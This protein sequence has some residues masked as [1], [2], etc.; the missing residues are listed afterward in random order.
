MSFKVSSPQEYFDTL[1]QRFIAEGA[2]GVTATYQF[3]LDPAG[4][5]HVNVEDG[6][7]SVHQGAAEKATT[8]FI[9]TGDNYVSMVNGDLNGQMAFM[10]GK[11]KIK[12]AIPMAMKLK[13]IFPQN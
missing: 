2:K 12:G 6:T 9:M 13:Q 10:T 8:T 1:D 5:W 4:T 11:M 7:F 3:N